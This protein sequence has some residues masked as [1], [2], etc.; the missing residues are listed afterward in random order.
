MKPIKPY[1]SIITLSVLALLTIIVWNIPGGMLILYPF[2]ILGTWFHEMAHGL[3]ALLFGG[4]FLRLELNSDGSGVAYFTGPL[5]FGNIGSAAVAMAGPIGP[6]IAGASFLIASVKNKPTTYLLYFLA[7]ALIISTII[8]VR[9]VFGVITTLSFG[10]A[11]AFIT[12]KGTENAKKITLQFLGLQAI[13][14]VY[15]SLGYLFSQGGVIE[16]RTFVSDTGVVQNNLFLPYWFWACL[17]IAIS[18]FAIFKSV[19]YIIKESGVAK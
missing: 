6:T 12:A 8:W 2:T 9:S 7:F 15:Q 14:S 18:I 11:I 13:I 10:L 17:I 4:S 1:L 5:L 3:T 19:K 16:G